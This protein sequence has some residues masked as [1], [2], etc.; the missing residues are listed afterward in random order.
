MI[1]GSGYLDIYHLPYECI[2]VSYAPELI[3]QLF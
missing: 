2:V 1:S 3:V